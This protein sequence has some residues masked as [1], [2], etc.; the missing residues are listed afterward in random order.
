MFSYDFIDGPE[1]GPLDLLYEPMVRLPL[2]R[3]S[4]MLAALP[5][6]QTS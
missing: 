2:W 1:K 3:T 6:L 4:C 5:S